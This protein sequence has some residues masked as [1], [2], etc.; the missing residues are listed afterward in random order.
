MNAALEIYVAEKRICGDLLDRITALE[1]GDA[2]ALCWFVKELN[3]SANTLRGFIA[4][5]EEISRRE[6]VP[7]CVLLSRQALRLIVQDA[8]WSRKEKQAR[9]RRLLRRWRFPE[10]ASIEDEM[11]REI[12][13][14]IEATGLRLELPQDMEG[15]SVSLLLR[16]RSP[17]DFP[18]IARKLLVLHQH[19]SSARLFSLLHGEVSDASS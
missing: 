14:L 2:E 19:P 15:D 13:K 18:E 8:G 9:V 1:E 11:E 3:P 7:L 10:M 16:V 5:L 17:D 4:L 6:S 12:A